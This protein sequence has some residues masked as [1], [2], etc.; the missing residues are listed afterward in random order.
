MRSKLFDKDHRFDFHSW[1]HR[2]LKEVCLNYGDS[3]KGFALSGDL[4]AR[5]EKL[6]SADLS[7]IRLHISSLPE[8]LG[9]EA[10]A[11]GTD[12]YFTSKVF[13]PTTAKGDAVIAHELVHVFQQ[14]TACDSVKQP[15]QPCLIWD[16][17][18][19]HE[20][21]R[22]ANL[23]YKNADTDVHYISKSYNSFQKPTPSS[24]R[25]DYLQPNVHVNVNGIDIKLTDINK[26]MRDILEGINSP[27]IA[28]SFMANY[29]D[30]KPIL[31]TWIKSSRVLWK[32]WITSRNERTV[33]YDSW[34]SL[35]RALLGE[36]RSEANL[37]NE[38]DLA[39]QTVDS[40][41]V[42]DKMTEF[43]AFINAMLNEQ[44]YAAVRRIVFPKIGSYSKKYSHWYPSGGIK[45]C[46]TDPLNVQFQHRV[47]AIHDVVDAFST[48]DEKFDIV[49]DSKCKG[50]ILVPDGVGGYTHHQVDL[51]DADGN[52]VFRD[53]HLGSRHCT[54]KEEN[55]II[56]S[57]RK[58][59]MPTGFGPSFTTGR[60][61]Q[62]C[63]RLCSKNN[64]HL[65]KAHWLNACAWGLFAFW[66]IYYEFKFSRSHRFQEV[67]DMARN[68]GVPWTP[69]SYPASCPNDDNPF[70]LGNGVI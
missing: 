1:G 26:A 45:K 19:E 35:A 3:T 18:L 11:H 24:V 69:Y 30:I 51:A 56:M 5:M 65:H 36:V 28:M 25:W 48:I 67:M 62:F 46:L 47:A 52:L 34:D 22:V 10:V 9:V 66:N 21:E 31:E 16:E 2:T 20:A 64:A 38:N 6:F 37:R 44:K 14:M 58:S 12:L 32:R 70:P 63:N 50:T 49:P 4:K 8:S 13:E 42:N 43:L 15:R 41:Y 33:G 7:E 55:E 53:G 57:Y 59:N 17:V 27:R 61:L 40:G 54:L 68:Y 60:T 39:R 29:L 23:V